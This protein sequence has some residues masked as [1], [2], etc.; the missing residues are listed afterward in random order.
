MKLQVKVKPNAKHQSVQTLEDGSLAIALK[1][2]PT[3]GK[4]NAELIEV[5]AKTFDV[6]KARITIKSGRAAR[7]KLIEIDL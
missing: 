5:L 6:P 7:I 4:A 1:S 3:D 2:P